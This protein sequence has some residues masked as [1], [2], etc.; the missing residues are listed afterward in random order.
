MQHERAW[1]NGTVAD[2]SANEACQHRLGSQ[3]KRPADVGALEAAEPCC[4]HRDASPRSLSK[5]TSNKQAGQACQTLPASSSSCPYAPSPRDLRPNTPCSSS[6]HAPVYGQQPHSARRSP[7]VLSQPLGEEFQEQQS[8]Q[9]SSRQPPPPPPPPV[10]HSTS[11]S[12]SGSQAGTVLGHVPNAD[13]AFRLISIPVQHIIATCAER[14]H[15]LIQFFERLFDGDTCRLFIGLHEDVADAV[16]DGFSFEALMLDKFL[17]LF[18]YTCWEPEEQRLLEEMEKTHFNTIRTS[19]SAVHNDETGYPRAQRLPDNHLDLSPSSPED[20]PCPPSLSQSP[21]S[22]ASSSPSSSSSSDWN[23]FNFSLADH[24]NPFT[25]PAAP[26]PA[27]FPFSAPRL[28]FSS[29]PPPTASFAPTPAPSLS[30]FSAVFVP[31]F[32]PP[33]PPPPPRVCQPAD[34][35]LLFPA[36]PATSVRRSVPHLPLWAAAPVSPPPAHPSSAP[37]PLQTWPLAKPAAVLSPA[38]A[39]Q[40]PQE[41][42]ATRFTYTDLPKRTG[43]NAYTFD[44]I[45][46][47]IRRIIQDRFQV[48]H[49]SRGNFDN[50]ICRRFM[51]LSEAAVLEVLAN[52]P[53]RGVMVNSVDHKIEKVLMAALQNVIHWIQNV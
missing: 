7:T 29:P 33:P 5:L 28:P 31:S 1:T 42:G 11:R 50:E 49:L 36:L 13:P 26:A 45:T 8:S 40:T 44:D 52:I 39:A 48:G 41:S 16:F 22:P 4:K 37:P 35:N 15:R 47:N 9:T 18:V 2:M 21:C 51:G 38:P 3:R 23:L 46:P 12:A 19:S 25:S 27:G 30:P 34:F 14:D 53:R 24:P 17:A 6:T 20:Y 10:S 32:A 43:Y